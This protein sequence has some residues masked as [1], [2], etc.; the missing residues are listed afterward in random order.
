[1]EVDFDVCKGHANCMAEAP[2]IFHV[3]GQGRLT[4]LNDNPQAELLQKALAA[5]KF[6]PS[7]AIRIVNAA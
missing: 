2:E 6:C 5:E 7:R 1:V 3:D 4:V